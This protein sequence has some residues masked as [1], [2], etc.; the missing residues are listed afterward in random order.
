M[1]ARATRERD[2]RHLAFAGGNG[3]GG[4][5]DMYEIRTA[6]G[7][8]GID[9]L[10][11]QIQVINQPARILARGISSA[12]KTI[13]ILDAQT[14]IRQCSERTLGMQ[15]RG[16]FIRCVPGGVLKCPHHKC[17]SF[18]AQC[19]TLALLPAAQPFRTEKSGATVLAA[20]ISV[21]YVRPRFKPTAAGPARNGHGPPASIPCPPDCAAMFPIF[22]WI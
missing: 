18:N 4:M 14:G 10:Q 1:A 12:K 2:Q 15:L 17:L 13:D 21:K 22:P 19:L 8:R 11:V 3:L 20:L 6:T 7:I 16:G 9:M 5:G